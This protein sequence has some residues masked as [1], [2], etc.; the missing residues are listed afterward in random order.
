[1]SVA[2]GA[3][4]E[5]PVEAVA[6]R[7][8][9]DGLRA[10]G[11]AGTIID[12]VDILFALVI[13]QV[14]DDM[15]RWNTI[16]A[17]AR[18]GLILVFAVTLGSWV[19]YHSSTNRE[20]GALSFDIFDRV[21]VLALGKLFTDVALVVLYWVAAHDLDISPVRP[22]GWAAAVITTAVATCY[23]IWDWLAFM[24]PRP[25]NPKDAARHYF[26][27]RRWS[28]IAYLMAAVMV[29]FGCWALHPRSD[30]SIAAENLLLMSLVIMYR[31]GKELKN[32]HPARATLQ[33]GAASQVAGA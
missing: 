8:A 27:W 1:M 22:T 25:V 11:P 9:S 7:E 2:E 23:V 18:T 5:L 6:P 17:D 16:A 19:G 24:T 3:E 15:L 14:L 10:T 32:E 28:S 4:P 33:V 30:W 21:E 13:G 29:L 20:T 31:L 12:F 26:A